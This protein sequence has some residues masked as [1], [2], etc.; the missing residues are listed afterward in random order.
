MIVAIHSLVWN[1]A[2]R[3]ILAIMNNYG[4]NIG[5]VPNATN[6]TVK[7]TPADRQ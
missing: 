4:H 5:L 6:A 7:K 3:I 2:I 1:L